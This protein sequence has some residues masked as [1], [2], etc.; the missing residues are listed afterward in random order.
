[1]SP[2]DSAFDPEDGERYP[3]PLSVN[4][5][6]AK[7]TEIPRSEKVS[8]GDIHKFWLHMYD[9]YDGLTDHDDLLLSLNGIPYIGML[10]PGDVIYEITKKDLEN[11]DRD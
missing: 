1:M 2:A 8:M 5:S 9:N 10:E 6:K 3:D 7:F 4:Y 11:F